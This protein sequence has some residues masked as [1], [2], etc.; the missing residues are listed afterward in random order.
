MLGRRGIDLE[1]QM[2]WRRMG[3]EGIG[4]PFPWETEKILLMSILEGR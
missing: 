2:R 1:G 3:G 4:K